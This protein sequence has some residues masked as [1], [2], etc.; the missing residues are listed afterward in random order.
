[1]PRPVAQITAKQPQG[2]HFQP[3]VQ[4]ENLEGRKGHLPAPTRSSPCSSQS[5]PFHQL[6]KLRRGCP[7][8]TQRRDNQQPA[9]GVL[10][11]GWATKPAVLA[12]LAA[13][14]LYQLEHRGLPHNVAAGCLE[15][16]S[17]QRALSGCKACCGWQG[18]WLQASYGWR[19]SWCKTTGFEG[20]PRFLRF[21]GHCCQSAAQ[22][23]F[24]WCLRTLHQVPP[25]SSSMKQSFQQPASS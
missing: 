5:A 9:Q 21:A 19:G 20:Q 23:N 6:P 1:M 14:L 24:I 13:Q 17:S 12:L 8:S 16:R 15:Q 3:G 25:N 22:Q 18:S 2:L 4:A 10:W 11:L 7:G